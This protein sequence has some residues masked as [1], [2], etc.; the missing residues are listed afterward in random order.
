M[1]EVSLLPKPYFHL[2][3]LAQT[4]KQLS[5]HALSQLYLNDVR[6]SLGPGLGSNMPL[7]LQWACWFGVLET[8]K[9]SLIGL[10]RAGVDIKRKLNQPFKNE[11]LYSLRYRTVKKRGPSGPA[12]G[13]LHWGSKSGLLHLT[14]LRGNTAI[15][16]LLIKNGAGPDAPDGKGLPALAYALNE[17]VV[18]CTRSHN[19]YTPEC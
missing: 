9:M 19:L 4:C 13:Y 3:N 10:Q 11:N 18:S 5:G 1:D 8:V 2:L 14:C 16:E 12:Y 6:D 17:D 7:A 15:A